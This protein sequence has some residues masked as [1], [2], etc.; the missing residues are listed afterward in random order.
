MCSEWQ[1]N[2]AAVSQ[3]F[4][5]EKTIGFFDVL[6]I[7][8]SFFMASE[9]IGEYISFK[10]SMAGLCD[11]AAAGL[12]I[13]RLKKAIESCRGFTVLSFFARSCELLCA[14]YGFFVSRDSP[15]A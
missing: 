5:D 13:K 3:N 7:A 11:A 1:T 12:A 14:I 15:E 2:E 9:S 10:S 4:S 8:V 6:L